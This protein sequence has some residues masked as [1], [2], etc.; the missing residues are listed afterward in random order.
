MPKLE[1]VLQALIDS[2]INITITGLW[3]NGLD[4]AFVSL[5]SAIAHDTDRAEDI[6]PGEVVDWQNVP[7]PGILA[8][9]IDDKARRLFPDSGYAARVEEQERAREAGTE[10]LSD[11]DAHYAYRRDL[12]ETL[13]KLYD[14]E[15]VPTIST[16]A[17]YAARY[18]LTGGLDFALVDSMQYAGDT[19]GMWSHV[20]RASHLAERLHRLVLR[21]LRD[22][23]YTKGAA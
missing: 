8:D 10:P 1:H 23:D 14:S 4:F 6:E 3:D 15:I 12:T 20:D 19:R 16:D 21:K 22:T 2:R 18:I 7:I 13:Q 17:T 9:T 5:K 11:I